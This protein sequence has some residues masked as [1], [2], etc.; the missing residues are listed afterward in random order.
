[1]V[2]GGTVLSALSSLE[3]NLNNY[4]SQISSLSS[5]K[6][7]SHD[8]LVSKAEE[9][10]SSYLSA[11]Q[12]QMN[13]FASAC[14]LYNEY[15]EVKRSLAVARSNYNTATDDYKNQYAGQV[16]SFQSKLDSLKGQIEGLL[17]S[18][19]SPSLASSSTSTSTT[20][21]STSSLGTPSFGTLTEHSYQAPNGL[22]LNYYLYIPNYG[23]PEV[24]SAT[25]LPVMLYMHG[26]GNNNYYG[27]VLERGL[28]KEINEKNINPSGLVVIP[29][30]KNFSDSRN[31]EALKSLVD[32]VVKNY[33]AD[34]NRISV[35]GHSNGAITTYK[36][37]N[38]YPN[39]FAAAIPISGFQQVTDSFKY[40][41]VW[42]FNGEYDHGNYTSNSGAQK[43]VQ[44]INSMGGVAKLYTYKGYGHSYVQDFTY[45]REFESPDGDVTT[46]LEWAMRQTKS[47]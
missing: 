43:A 47:A 10:A 37:I 6:G 23:Q 27:G 26:G 30:I 18:A 25:G 15:E 42:A 38:K 45:E 5:W 19:S 31:L 3:S 4:N 33:N 12:G 2:S 40:T 9:F 28:A 8:N 20:V 32:D 22:K 41:K 7:A 16:S 36:L 35:S 14:D 39:Y 24:T 21:S 1:M 17:A 11:I 34:A 44:Q 29:Y 46:P 13:S